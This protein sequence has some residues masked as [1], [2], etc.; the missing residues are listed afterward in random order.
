MLY[1]F[2]GTDSKTAR[3]K[4]HS[5]IGNTE[6]LLKVTPDTYDEQLIWS[7]LSGSDLFTPYTHI[8]FDGL[9][10]DSRTR[11]SFESVVPQLHDA[12]IKAYALEGSLELAARKFFERNNATLFQYDV[13]K[14]VAGRP[15]FSLAQAFADKKR[16][17]A[18]VAY[19][20]ALMQGAAPEAIHGMLFWKLKQIIQGNTTRSKASVRGLVSQITELPLN[21]RE[22]GVEFEYALERFLLE[23]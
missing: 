15:D 11:E 14:G 19:Q 13:P 2:F 9:W 17:E 21:A 4:A 18:W 20:R 7:V 5:H 8:M 12:Q 1:L 6:S 23:K 16:A 3:S 22:R 10:G